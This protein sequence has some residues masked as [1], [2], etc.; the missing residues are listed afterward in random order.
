MET[1][2]VWLYRGVLYGGYIGIMEN[3]V[4]TTISGVGLRG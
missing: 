1:T 4:D 3:E 2:I